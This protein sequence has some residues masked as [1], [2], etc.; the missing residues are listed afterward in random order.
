MADRVKSKDGR[1]ETEEIL[2]ERGTVS[3]QG[4]DG[5]ALARDI[6]TR[7]ELKR[8]YERPAGSTGVDKSDKED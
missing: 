7:D 2:G 1:R 6:A 4:R 8:A 5:T 3:H